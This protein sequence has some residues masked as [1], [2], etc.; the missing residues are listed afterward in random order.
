MLGLKNL[1]FFSFHKNRFE[2]DQRLQFDNKNVTKIYFAGEIL[3]RFLLT[4]KKYFQMQKL[5]SFVR[6]QNPQIFS[7]LLY[8]PWEISKLT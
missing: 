7:L 1:R 3:D 4:V 2:T 8:S 5:L 6:P